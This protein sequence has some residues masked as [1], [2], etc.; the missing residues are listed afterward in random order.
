MQNAGP[1]LQAIRKLGEKPRCYSRRETNTEQTR[2]SSGEPCD[3]KV[4][5]TV[6]RGLFRKGA[7]CHLARQLPYAEI[8]FSVFSRQCLD[9]RIPDEATLKMQIAAL[10]AERN[11][12]S[13]TVNWRFTS[14]NARVKLKRLYP[15]TST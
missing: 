5:S 13:A 1:I 14:P 15:V 6:R 9:D 2:R 12:A 3:M 7:L 10:Q 4:S 11:A 8:E